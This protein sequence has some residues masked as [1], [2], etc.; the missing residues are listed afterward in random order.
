MDQGVWSRRSQR[1][2]QQTRFHA[3]RSRGGK[4][5]HTGHLVLLLGQ[6]RWLRLPQG[7]LGGL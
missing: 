2:Q 7:R 5:G 3:L 6:E 4:F 1:H